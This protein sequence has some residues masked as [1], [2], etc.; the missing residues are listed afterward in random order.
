MKYF[1]IQENTLFSIEPPQTMFEHLKNM[2][3]YTQTYINGFC[4]SNQIKHESKPQNKEE[5]LN[6]KKEQRKERNYK[7]QKCVTIKKKTKKK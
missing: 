6:T 2:Q 7:H 1:L 4:H 3:Y 5:R